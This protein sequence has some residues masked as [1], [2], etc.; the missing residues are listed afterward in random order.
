MQT[1]N[2]SI[3]HG[4]DGVSFQRH[5]LNT[6]LQHDWFASL[7]VYHFTFILYKF[8][9]YLVQIISIIL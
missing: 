1:D 4:V 3:I 2:F 7:S 6:N 5:C 8:I 9:N